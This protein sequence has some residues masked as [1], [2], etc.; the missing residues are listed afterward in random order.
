M[1][2]VNNVSFKARNIEIRRADDIARLV[3][4]KYPMLSTSKL[5]GLHMAPLYEKALK[6]ADEYLSLTRAEIFGVLNPFNNSTNSDEKILNFLKILK[7]TKIG[8]CSEMCDLGM[9]FAYLKNI[10]NIHLVHIRNIAGEYLDHVTLYVENGKKPYI[11]DPWL[12]FADYV[13]ETL[14]RY[15]SEF[16]NIFMLDKFS[17]T[18]LFFEKY[19]YEGDVKKTLQKCSF[20]EIFRIKK[21]I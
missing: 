15:K 14:I 21:Q 17:D 7:R 1:L 19:S 20:I 6:K 4:R 3:A 9:I 8:N 11:I 10:K 2:E 13:P 16:K 5:G 18:N 12:G